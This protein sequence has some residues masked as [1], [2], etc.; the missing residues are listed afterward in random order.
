MTQRPAATG[1]INPSSGHSCSPACTSCQLLLLLHNVLL[2]WRRR[3]QITL[4][5]S[6]LTPL[7]SRLSPLTLRLSPLASHL[8]PLASRLTTGYARASV[9][10]V[11]AM[12]KE[13]VVLLLLRLLTPHAS[14]LAPRASHL[15]PRGQLAVVGNSPPLIA[16][17]APLLR[18]PS[19]HL[20]YTPVVPESKRNEQERTRVHGRAH[21][22]ERGRRR[23]EVLR[24]GEKERII[25]PCRAGVSIRP[26]ARA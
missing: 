12:M 9:Q 1:T 5:A 25:S 11:L 22:E 18:P 6:H 14:R 4:H 15:T 16:N 13:L 19:R 10:V 17:K 8:T 23:R 26:Q 7:A 20:V 24:G 2:G 3:S 21:W